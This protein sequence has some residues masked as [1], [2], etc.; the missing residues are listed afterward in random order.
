MKMGETRVSVLLH[1]PRGHAEVEM[2]VDT[3][4]TVTKIPVS[5]ANRLGIFPAYQA[6]VQLADGRVVER[7]ESEAQVELDGRRRTIPVLIGPDKEE[8]LLGLTT[9]EILKLKVNPVTQ[10]LEPA[11]WIEYSLVH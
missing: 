5:I 1:G 7:G 3:G 10:R 9:L 2:L 8:P 6:E 4:A 11:K